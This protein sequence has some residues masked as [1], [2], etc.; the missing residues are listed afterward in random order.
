ML[1]TFTVEEIF[2]WFI[3]SC[4]LVEWSILPTYMNDLLF[5][6]KKKSRIHCFSDVRK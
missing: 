3:K 4:Y 2:V 1:S 6:Q 5:Q